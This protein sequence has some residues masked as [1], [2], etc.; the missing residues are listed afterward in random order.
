MDLADSVLVARISHADRMSHPFHGHDAEVSV[1]AGAR[2]DKL[3]G[4]LLH[5]RVLRWRA[6][7]ADAPLAFRDEL[8]RRT[9][10]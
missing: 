6:K 7:P 2:P 5:D 1:V 8:R 4:L 10:A 9:G 3:A